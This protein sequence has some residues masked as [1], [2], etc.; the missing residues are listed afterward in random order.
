MQD[1]LILAT[2]DGFLL[3]LKLAEDIYHLPPNTTVEDRRLWQLVEQIATGE[4]TEPETDAQIR[5]A[6]PNTKDVGEQRRIDQA[7]L[8]EAAK[9][10]AQWH[11]GK[12]GGAG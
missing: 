12:T 1:E 11:R 2:A 3:G 6:S 5:E 10:V 9:H 4:I 8:Q 7:A